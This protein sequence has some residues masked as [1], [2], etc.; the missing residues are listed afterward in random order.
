M[1][2]DQDADVALLQL[3]H[4]VADIGDGEGVDSG[5][6]FVE[7]HDL[8]LRGQR[9]GDLAA[10]SFAARKRDCRRCPERDQP[11]FVEQPF[12]PRAPCGSV[13]LGDLEHR[14]DIL[15]HRHSAKNA[16]FLREIAKP[17]NRATIHRKV[18]DIAPVE[19][20][21]PGVGFDQPHHRVK[22]GGLARA[23]G[24]EQADHLAAMNAQRD[25]VEHRALV[26]GLGDRANLEPAHGRVR[27]RGGDEVAAG[28]EH[29]PDQLPRF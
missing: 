7:E 4:Q 24:A 10:P 19:Q 1:I 15:L 26:I 16:G 23:V 9:P 12:K 21:P 3:H 8:G 25:V 17:E 6:R 28:I 18:R 14:R 29:R 11:E 27:V 2:G 5:K 13:G 22:T 20:D